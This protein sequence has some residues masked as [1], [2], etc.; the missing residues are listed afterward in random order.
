MVAISSTSI[1][2]TWSAP[3]AEEQNGVITS[4]R[5]TITEVESEERVLE[6]T[7]AASDTLL[8][9]N[10]LDPHFT[11]HCSIAAVTIAIGPKTSA[12]VTTFQEGN[13]YHIV[14]TIATSK[15]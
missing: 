6:R 5:V 4:Y 13:P 9:V 11:Y 2:L 8:I 10:S 7:A 14:C 12:E 15:Y 1:R 3:L